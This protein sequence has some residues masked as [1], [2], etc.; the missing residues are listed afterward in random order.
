MNVHT[1]DG[2]GVASDVRLPDLPVGHDAT[3]VYV[4]DYGQAGRRRSGSRSMSLTR[5]P[6]GR[7]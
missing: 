5:I 1:L 4:I 3:S 7:Q 6:V 2:V